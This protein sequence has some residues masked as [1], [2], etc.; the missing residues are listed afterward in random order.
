M[1]ITLHSLNVFVYSL[2]CSPTTTAFFRLTAQLSEDAESDKRLRA[3]NPGHLGSTPAKRDWLLFPRLPLLSSHL[4]TVPS[5]PRS[6]WT[7]PREISVS[8]SC[9]QHKMGLMKLHCNPPVST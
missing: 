9:N 1:L 5:L 7:D 3:G 8:R 4:T 2:C 6:C